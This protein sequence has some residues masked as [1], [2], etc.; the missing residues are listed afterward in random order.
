MTNTNHLVNETLLQMKYARVVSLLAERLDISEPR[1]LDLF[2]NSKTYQYMIDSNEML[3]IDFLKR[4]QIK[5]AAER[6]CG[7]LYA[8]YYTMNRDIWLDEE[9]EEWRY[10]TEKRFQQYCR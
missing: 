4:G 6:A 5:E 3:I 2:Y 1:A 7:M 8:T 9:C 10:V